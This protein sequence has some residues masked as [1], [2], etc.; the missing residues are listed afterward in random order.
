VH[1]NYTCLLIHEIK[2]DGFLAP[3]VLG[4]PSSIGI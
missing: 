1:P 3:D 4:Q 2:E